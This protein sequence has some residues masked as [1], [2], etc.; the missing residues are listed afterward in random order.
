MDGNGM[1]KQWVFVT[2]FVGENRGKEGEYQRLLSLP[3]WCLSGL[4]CENQ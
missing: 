2:S 1:D 3:S 4:A